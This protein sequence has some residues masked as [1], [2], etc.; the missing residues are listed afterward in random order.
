MKAIDLYLA[1]IHFEEGYKP[2][3]Y[4]CSEGYPTVGIGWR[5]GVKGADIKDFDM[6]VTKPVAKVMLLDRVE[7][8]NN[9]LVKFDWYKNLNESRKAIVISMAYQMSIRKMLKFKNMIAALAVGDFN[10]A[11]LEAIDSRWFEQ[12]TARAAR[13]A[14]TLELGDIELVYGDKLEGCRL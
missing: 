3:P 10:K 4:Y 2:R 7:H 14:N 6:Y 8:I 13:H 9:R 12:T 1:L 5:I 11:R